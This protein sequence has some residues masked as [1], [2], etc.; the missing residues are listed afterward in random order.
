MKDVLLL[1]YDIQIVNGDILIDESRQQDIEIICKTEKGQFYQYPK[2]GV[3]IEKMING[4]RTPLEVK[5]IIRDNLNQDNFNIKEI[6]VTNDYNI[7]IDAE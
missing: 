5:S 7:Y 2:L 1:E 6:K 3:G 4:S